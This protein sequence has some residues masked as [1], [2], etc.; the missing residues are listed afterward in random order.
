MNITAE[1]W[2]QHF[3]VGTPVAYHPILD[4]EKSVLTKTR[5]EAWTL[6]C[7]NS[8]VKIEGRTGGVL[9]ESLSV[10]SNPAT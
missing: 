10:I 8:V 5:S 2:N 6:G 3:P 4:E 1:K 7:G 9:L